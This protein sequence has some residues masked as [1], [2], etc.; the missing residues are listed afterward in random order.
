MLININFLSCHTR[1]GI[2]KNFRLENEFEGMKITIIQYA[3]YNMTKTIYEESL[4]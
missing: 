4:K 2:M 3:I 1:E